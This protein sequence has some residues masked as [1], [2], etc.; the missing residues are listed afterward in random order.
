MVKD[1]KHYKQ[2][3]RESL[4]RYFDENNLRFDKLLNFDLFVSEGAEQKVYIKDHK[5]VYKLNDAIYYETWEDYLINLQL[6]NYFFPETAYVLIGFCLIEEILYALV[7][8]PFVTA[9]EP[10]NLQ[11]VKKFMYSNGFLKT[12]NHDYFN[13]ELKIILED[14]HDEN[15]LAKGG[16]HYFIDTVFYLKK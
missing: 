13:A 5:T 7:E 11:L 2:Q 3:E 12:R 14:L 4:I 16:V 6:N 15:V 8:Q 10:T 1:N 9:N